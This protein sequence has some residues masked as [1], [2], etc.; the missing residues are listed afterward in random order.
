[1]GI[2]HVRRRPRRLA[3]GP[4]LTVPLAHSHYAGAVC[5]VWRAHANTGGVV[6]HY[7]PPSPD[8]IDEAQESST[9][10][11]CAACASTSSANAAGG[12]PRS[13]ARS[14]TSSTTRRSASSPRTTA[15]FASS[16]SSGWARTPAG[17]AAP[18]AD[19]PDRG[20]SRESAPAG[21]MTAAAREPVR[22]LVAHR[23][24]VAAARATRSPPRRR[25]RG[26][27]RLAERVGDDRPAAHAP[28][29]PLPDAV[30]D[31]RCAPCLRAS[32]TASTA[33]APTRATAARRA[34]R[35][36]SRLRRLLARRTGRGCIGAVA[37]YLN[38]RQSRAKRGQGRGA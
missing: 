24:R 25:P 12:T 34:G 28:R 13:T 35:E 32:G 26:L 1:M 33:A 5:A 23:L 14:T 18:T 30:V 29:A 37:D 10:S 27:A 11:T 8:A 20:Q 16:S 36:A 6:E 19:L 17:R 21:T 22:T 9:R 15:T 7:V 38:A 31:G 2:R 4:W 3:R